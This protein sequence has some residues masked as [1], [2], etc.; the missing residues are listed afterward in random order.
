MNASPQKKPLPANHASPSPLAA[1]LDDRSGPLNLR[2]G[3][4]PFLI[5]KPGSHDDG[6]E[7][8]CRRYLGWSRCYAWRGRCGGL[9][10]ARA[11][12]VERL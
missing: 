9:F 3:D 1:R 4:G 5:R 7:V 8:T 10:F 6:Q 2:P 11:D 12:Q